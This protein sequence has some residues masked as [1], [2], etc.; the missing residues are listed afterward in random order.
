MILTHGDLSF[1]ALS[2]GAGPL[3]LC[4]H[5]FPDNA[6]SFRHQLPK[7]AEAGYHAVSVMLRGYEPSSQPRDRDYTLETI[8]GD[9]LAFIDQLGAGRAHLIGH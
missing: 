9:V 2:V 3:V 1:T 5:G 4:L 6:R 8:A 7:L